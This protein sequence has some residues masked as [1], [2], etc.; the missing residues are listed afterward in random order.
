MPLKR[1]TVAL[2]VSVFAFA[3]HAA[4]QKNEVSGLVGRTFVTDQTITA[5]TLTDNKLRFGNGLSFEGNYARRIMGAGLLSLSLEVPVVVNPDEDLHAAAPNNVPESY[6]SYFVTPA[7]RLNLFS[8]TGVSPWVS[9]G[10]GVGHFSESSKLLFGGTNPSKTGTTTGVFQ[11]G[12]GVDVR[13]IRRF[14]V[15]GELRDFWSGTPKTNVNTGNSRQHNLFV[16]GGL[17]WHF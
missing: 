16:G 9:V 11:A 13:L 8:A 2:M 7:G 15:R 5:S 1:L 14:S 12:V 10:G 4:A 17:V 3:A 6:R